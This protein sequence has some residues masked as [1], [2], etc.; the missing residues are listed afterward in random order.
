MAFWIIIVIIGFSGFIIFNVSWVNAQNNCEEIETTCYRAEVN[1]AGV[2]MV[3]TKCSN[4]WDRQV[5]K[6]I[7]LGW[8]WEENK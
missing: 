5:K 1:W 3:P 7:D 6:C 8:F 4:Y 2:L